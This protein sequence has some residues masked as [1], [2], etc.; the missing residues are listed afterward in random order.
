MPDI[1]P[2]FHITVKQRMEDES[3]KYIPRAKWRPGSETYVHDLFPARELEVDGGLG[4][5]CA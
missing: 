3:L 1:K 4:D 5:L 2:N